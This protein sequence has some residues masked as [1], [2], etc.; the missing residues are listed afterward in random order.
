MFV[1]A[2]LADGVAADGLL[3][4]QRGVTRNQRGMP[5][6]LVVNA[7]N[8]VELRELKADRAVGDK[9]L[10]TDGLSAGDKVIVEGVQ[11]VRPGVEVI[12]TEAKANAP[13]APQPQAAAAAKQQ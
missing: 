8:Q 5:T 13:Q 7:K 12:A 1:R 10:V 3:V 9:W 6:A 11:M 2:R 4:P